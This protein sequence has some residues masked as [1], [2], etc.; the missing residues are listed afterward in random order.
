MQRYVGLAH[1]GLLLEAL[2][3]IAGQ[4]PLPGA[5]GYLCQRPCEA[6]CR[7]AEVDR[8]VAIRWLK[9]AAARAGLA[10]GARPRRQA[11]RPGPWRVAVVGAGPAGLAAAR[12][13][14]DRGH[15]VTL[16]ERRD[17]PGGLLDEVV[18][19]F[20]MPRRVL[21]ADI[22]AILEHPGVELRTGAEVGP[23]GLSDLR[24]EGFAAVILATGSGREVASEPTGD[25]EH[26]LTF[27]RRA[28]RRELG[29]PGR[30]ALVLGNTTSAV[31]VARTLARGGWSEVTLAASRPLEHWPADPE[32][33]AAAQ[34]EGV[35]LRDRFQARGDE[36]AELCI[37]DRPR[38]P[39][40]SALSGEPG[41]ELTPRGAFQVD[42]LT[43][44]TGIAG[45]FAAGECATG[46]KT[47]VEAL[48]AGKRAA[49]MVD[50]YLAGRPLREAIP[51]RARPWFELA[52]L[53]NKPVEGASSLPAP[54]GEDGDLAA[55]REASRC[56][57]C[58]P[59]AECDRC[60]PDC[61][62]ERAVTISNGRSLI[63]RAPAGRAD[64][65]LA[66]T[67][68]VDPERCTGCGRCEAACPHQAVVVRFR[69][70][71]EGELVRARV[72]RPACRGCGRCVPACPFG[73]LEL[74][75]GHHDA[76]MLWDAIARQ[77]VDP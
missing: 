66:L 64:D 68:K 8:P 20:R 69:A 60:M 42:P 54:T 48:A 71:S 19:D 46:P 50:R 65:A 3:V 37:G 53:E 38:L 74:A 34:R 24:R 4:C 31:A 18:P 51:R 6:A 44:E 33:L 15:R 61:L 1:R 70:T 67:V 35:V 55:A 5:C 28:A 47:V 59:C 12:S 41:M 56:L 30:E 22:D 23:E 13:L 25:S 76:H 9:R 16:L 7:R 58:G 40:A 17:R 73:A 72:E 11:W 62:H 43:L 32:D 63:I 10:A 39:D 49:L 26:P 52:V 29:E 75:P 27:L 45:V 36:S 2:D 57:R 77:V 14:T 21:R